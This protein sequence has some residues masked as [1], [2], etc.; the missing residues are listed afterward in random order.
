MSAHFTGN[1]MAVTT[2][3][4]RNLIQTTLE[5]TEGDRRETVSLA[6]IVP[7]EPTQTL[8]DVQIAAALR[9][10]ELLKRVLPAELRQETKS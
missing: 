2:K 4:G 6:V 9:A 7:E 5:L 1:S 3:D 8:R 10:I